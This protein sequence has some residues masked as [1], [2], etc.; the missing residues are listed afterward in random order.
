MMLSSIKSKKG[1][2]KWH[3]VAGKISGGIFLVFVREGING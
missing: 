2:K 1:G 3:H